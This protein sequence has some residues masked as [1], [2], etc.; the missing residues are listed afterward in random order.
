M[1]GIN[2]SSLRIV[3]SVG[4]PVREICGSFTPLLLL[5]ALLCC[6]LAMA[7]PQWRK[8]TADHSASG[9]DIIIA[10]DVSESMETEDFY[11]DN[12]VGTFR[13]KKKRVSAAKQVIESFIQNRTRDRIGLIAFGPKPYSVCPVTLDH[14]WLTS[15]LSELGVGNLDSHGTAVGS[16][17]AAAATRLNSRK[18][19]SKVV[20]L[21]TDG[22]SNSGPLTPLQAAKSTSLLGIKVYTIAIGTTEGRLSPTDLAQPRQQY[23]AET[24]RQIASI[25]GGAFFEASTMK[26]LHDTFASIDNLEK[27]EAQSAVI[28]ESIELYPWLLGVALLFSVFSLGSFVLIPLPAP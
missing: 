25:T 16:A 21:V 8:I 27:S 23:D 1:A 26:S 14:A 15:R 24:L 2:L 10:L 13:H 11:E 12:A 19:K 3:S 18:A 17:I 20:V 4:T 7:R 6:G 28:I 22:A 9:I 5:L